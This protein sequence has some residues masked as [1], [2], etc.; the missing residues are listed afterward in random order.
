[1][2]DIARGG[3][4]FLVARGRLFLPVCTLFQQAFII[5]SDG[6]DSIYLFF[7]HFSRI[8]CPGFASLSL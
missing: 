4:T 8:I 6:V 2:S 1:V 7:T 5:A 3:S